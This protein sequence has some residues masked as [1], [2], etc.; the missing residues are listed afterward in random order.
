M[1]KMEIDQDA[2]QDLVA[3]QAAAAMLFARPRR[4]LTGRARWG[5]D[6]STIRAYRGFDNPLEH[7]NQWAEF[8]AAE[9]CK[10][11]SRAIDFATEHRE[12]SAD[13]AEHWQSQGILS[14]AQ[15]FKLV[16]LFILRLAYYDRLDLPARELLVAEGHAAL[17]K[18]TLRG[19]A[20]MVPG[21]V[22]GNPSMG[23]IQDEAQYRALQLVIRQITRRA[24]VPNLNFDIWC[25]PADR[26]IAFGLPARSGVVLPSHHTDD[27]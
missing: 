9:L 17:D 15:T 6:R 16:D 27:D 5:V 22:I 20:R 1:V 14:V 7:Y 11:E 26:R 25:W 19:L 10:K 3:D 13:L 8:R 23:A 21:L 12:L 4:L 18:F 2:L 24:G